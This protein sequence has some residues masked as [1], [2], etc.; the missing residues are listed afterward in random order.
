M[1]ETN[2]QSLLFLADATV[3]MQQKLLIEKD[4]SVIDIFAVSHHGSK[5]STSRALLELIGGDDAI[6]S[7]G[8]NYYGHPAKE[9]LDALKRWGYNVYRTDLDGN[10]EIVIGQ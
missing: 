7:V 6:I 2:G 3:E 5:Y 8:H 10:I 1:L 9:T 4:L